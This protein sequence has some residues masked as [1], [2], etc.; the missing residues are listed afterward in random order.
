MATKE[1]ELKISIHPDQPTRT[2]SI[3]I[4]C[5]KIVLSPGLTSVP[6]TL[7]LSTASDH[8]PALARHVIHAKEV[9]QWCRDNLG[10][11]PIP[12]KDVSSQ[13]TGS[14]NSD[15]QPTR[16]PHRVAIYGGA[17][18]SFDLVHMFATLHLNDPSFHLKGLNDTD[19]IK[20]VQVHWII[21]EGG[22]GPAW[23]S[24]PRSNMPN[25]ESIASDKVA[26]TRFVGVP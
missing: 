2:N 25:G 11:Q 13:E 9:G 8:P 20:P 14:H 21:R 5:D 7:K 24:P 22:S 23:M 12:G 4:I 3:T 1:W 10:Y 15:A 6:N 26:S 19:S 17:K 16:V 18:S